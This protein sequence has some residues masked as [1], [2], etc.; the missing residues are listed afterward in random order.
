MKTGHLLLFVTGIPNKTSGQAILELFRGF[1][2]FRI[3][4]LK[5]SGEQMKILNSSPKPNLKRGFCILEAS[6]THSFTKALEVESLSLGERSLKISK[7]MY[8]TQL[9]QFSK[10]E[11]LRRV[12]IKKIPWSLSQ[13]HLTNPL[14]EAF[15]KVKRIFRYMAPD[16]VARPR[17]KAGNYHTYSVEFFSVESAARAALVGNLLLPD[18]DIAITIEKFMRKNEIKNKEITM[19][20]GSMKKLSSKTTRVF[21]RSESV[22]LQKDTTQIAKSKP[23]QPAKTKLAQNLASAATLRLSI[24]KEFRFLHSAKPSSMAYYARRAE[25]SSLDRGI[26][27]LFLPIAGELRFNLRQ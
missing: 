9:R 15:G 11:E 14:E 5:N 22:D 20:L 21:E 25:L 23:R 26:A 18:L 1:G 19:E 4:C 27:A 6:D 10:E 7:F 13:D 12:I 3:L 17:L 16:K 2:S 8:G 24:G